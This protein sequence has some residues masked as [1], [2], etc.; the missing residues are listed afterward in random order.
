MDDIITHMET[1]HVNENHDLVL[2]VRGLNI[3]QC[4]KEQLLHLIENDNHR[5]YLTIYNILV[6]ND[7]ELPPLV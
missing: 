1:M 7:I 2:F 5:D 4:K 3:S 6:E